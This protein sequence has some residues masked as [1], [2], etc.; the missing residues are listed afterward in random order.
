MYIGSI[1]YIEQLL[2]RWREHLLIHHAAWFI[3]RVMFLSYLE[4]DVGPLRVQTDTDGF[5]FS[6]Q[7]LLLSSRFGGVQ[8]DHDQICRSGDSD[9]LFSST[10]NAQGQISV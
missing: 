3:V 5:Q 10:I 1:K 7:E 6:L 4:V 9:N 8:H 2:L